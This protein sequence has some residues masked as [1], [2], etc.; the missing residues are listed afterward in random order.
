MPV[1]VQY[2]CKSRKET[3]IMSIY[4]QYFPSEMAHIREHS[5]QW[6]QRSCRRVSYDLLIELKFA[7]GA[8]LYHESVNR[9]PGKWAAVGPASA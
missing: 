1:T 4:L 9:V 2:V 3:A 6:R 7:I 8:D 5:R